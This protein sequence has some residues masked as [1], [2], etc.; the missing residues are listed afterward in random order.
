M[1]T[2][3]N[4]IPG[5]LELYNRIL[6]VVTV[7]GAPLGSR[8]LPGGWNAWECVAQI[9]FMVDLAHW[10]KSGTKP[11]RALFK[12]RGFFIGAFL[13]LWTIIS[14]LISLARRSRVL[15]FSVDKTSA[16]GAV[17]F[18]IERVYTH[19]RKQ[20]IRYVELFHT[21]VRFATIQRTVLK[22]RTALYLEGIDWMYYCGAALRTNPEPIIGG[23]ESFTEKESR[24]IRSFVTKY[25]QAEG[26]FAFRIKV[27]SWFLQRSVTQVIFGIDDARCYQSLAA[28]SHNSHKPF[29]AFQHGHITPYNIAWLSD[30]RLQGARAVPTKLVVWNEYWKQ[31]LLALKSVWRPDDIIVAGSPKDTRKESLRRGSES[32]VVVPFETEAPR[33]VI[34]QIVEELHAAGFR[35]LFKLRPDKPTAYQL[36]SLGTSR[37]Y[38]EPVSIVS[39]PVSAV[40]GTYSTYLYDALAEGIPVGVVRTS[41]RYAERLVLSGMV[42]TLEVG[43]VASGVRTLIE[44]SDSE[45][46]A[47][48]AR[49]VPIDRFTEVLGALLKDVA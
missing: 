44:L 38:V 25:V 9:A 1:A 5:A 46:A 43:S 32:V 7:D 17:D 37:E 21:E 19:L 3:L 15:V 13:A 41:L 8:L 20:H 30:A 31:E 6:D 26:M 42:G 12:F 27:L 10:T 36:D 45:C 47:R 49:V 40:I 28:A 14:I 11:D 16:T 23:L 39:E 48:A 34:A 24:I 22:G 35:V 33:G 4:G 2:E 18:R 29:Y